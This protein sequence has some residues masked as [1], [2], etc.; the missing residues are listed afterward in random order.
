[1]EPSHSL[2][3]F[4]SIVVVLDKDS[5]IHPQLHKLR[6]LEIKTVYASGSKDMFLRAGEGFEHQNADKNH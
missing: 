3:I 4:N 1:M 2:E 5:L 6:Y